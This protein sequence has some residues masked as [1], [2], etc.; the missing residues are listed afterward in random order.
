VPERRWHRLYFDD[1]VAAEGLDLIHGYKID[2]V[3][4]VPLRPWART[5]GQAVWM[6]LEGTGGL[7]GGYICEIAPGQELNP[8]RQLF[9]ELILILSGQ[10][11]S[12]VWYEGQQKASFEWTAGSLFAIPLNA[13]H[14]HFNG[15]GGTPVRFLSVT[16]APITMNL[17]RDADFIFN[18][19]ATFPDR[20]AGQPGYFAGEFKMEEFTGWGFPVSV[21]FSNLYPDIH[22][23]PFSDVNRGVGVRHVQYELANGVSSAHRLEMPGGTFTKLH[24]HGPGAHVLW[25]GGEGYT[26]M[27]PDG[28]DM[29][30][31]FW[32]PG[33]M[34]VPPE[35]WWH[36]HA[37]VSAEPGLHFALNFGSRTNSVT[38]GNM[39]S[40]KSAR[41]GGN[42]LEY[43]D[44]PRDTMDKLVTMFAEECARR[45]TPARMEAILGG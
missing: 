44:I 14:Q 33:T 41:D 4:S 10:G 8:K 30:Q 9:E 12:M 39:A 2:D 21:A 24:R 25:L 38:K 31:E 3:H 20:Y 27:W 7:N 28:G 40:M 29:I 13:W 42:Q 37:V 15:S 34:M 18:C 45:G 6:Q 11:S 16:T 32:R 36:Q 5:G 26:V 1:W 35:G 43:E 22:A 17:I 19:D 23:V